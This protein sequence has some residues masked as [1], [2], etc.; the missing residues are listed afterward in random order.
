MLGFRSAGG[1]QIALCGKCATVDL[2]REGAHKYY[3]Y[4]TVADPGGSGSLLEPSFETK[5]MEIFQKN[6]EK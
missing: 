2:H 3:K 1:C 5:S 4:S 6:Q